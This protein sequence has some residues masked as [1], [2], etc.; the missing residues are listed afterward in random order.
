MDED[1]LL[2]LLLL[3]TGRKVGVGWMSR[4]VRAWLRWINVSYVFR[5]I[6]LVYYFLFPA[7]SMSSGIAVNRMHIELAASCPL[8]SD[9]ESKKAFGETW[10][11]FRLLCRKSYVR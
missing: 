1:R 4:E 9:D 6:L 11:G 8:S 7:S 2:L 5:I 10:C 3:L